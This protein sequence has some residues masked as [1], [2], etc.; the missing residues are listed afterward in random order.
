M[1]LPA[2]QQHRQR[3]YYLDD[4]TASPTR[5]HVVGE[6]IFH[7]VSDKLPEGG[8]WCN[9]WGPPADYNW[10]VSGDTLTLVPVGGKDA[11]GIRGF[12]WTGTWTR[13]G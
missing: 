12:I 3:L 11:C 10:S 8:S 6:V 5:L 2:K 9:N 7:P 13:V 4:Y 1:G